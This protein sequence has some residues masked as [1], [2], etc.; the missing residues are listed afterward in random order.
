MKTYIGNLSLFYFLYTL[1]PVKNN[2]KRPLRAYIYALEVDFP[3]VAK[4]YQ[5]F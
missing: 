1:P 5:I 4:N 3:Q 2:A